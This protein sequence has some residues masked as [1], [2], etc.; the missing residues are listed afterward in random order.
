MGVSIA[1]SQF[2]LQ[3]RWLFNSQPARLPCS[4]GPKTVNRL[5]LLLYCMRTFILIFPLSFSSYEQFSSLPI[6]AGCLFLGQVLSLPR[7]GR[8]FQMDT[9]CTAPL[10]NFP[11]FA[12]LSV[13]YPR[14][15]GSVLSQ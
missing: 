2:F 4:S 6:D 10:L 13:L 5:P 1:L 11:F 12:Q 15:L 14:G 3:G 7:A 8:E 9:T